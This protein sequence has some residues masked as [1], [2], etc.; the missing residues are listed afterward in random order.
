MAT[1]TGKDGSLLI[2]ASALTQMRSWTL[3][4]TAEPTEASVIG[5]SW[6]N[7]KASMQGYTVSVEGYYDT[8]D[9]GQVALILGTEVAFTLDP[10]GAVSGEKQY[11][12]NAYVTA[13]SETASFDGM[14]EFTCSL[15]GNGALVETAVTP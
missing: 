11:D 7:F 4:T 1:F 14:V 3:E 10:A 6:R 15:Q 2:G 5:D 8:E 9:T 12:G 13:Y